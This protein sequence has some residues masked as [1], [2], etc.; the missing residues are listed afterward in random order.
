M[1]KVGRNAQ[2]P[3]GSGKKYKACHGLNRPYPE[4]ENVASVSISPEL[5]R[6]IVVTK[7]VLVNQIS[8]D[9]PLIAKSFDRLTKKDIAEI[10]AVVADAM[11][12]MFRYSIVD[13]DEYKPTCS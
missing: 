7:D 12:L 9:G 1:K 6:T 3:C 8:R 10:S 11:S 2:C 4:V 13:S 5:K